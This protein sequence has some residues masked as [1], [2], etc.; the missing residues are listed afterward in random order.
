M[1][2]KVD[3]A[4]ETTLTTLSYINT[5]KRAQEKGYKVSLIYFWLRNV[6]LAIQRV[7]TRV[8]EGGHAIPEEVIKRRYIKGIKNLTQKFVP[9]C[10]Y[11]LV[12]DNSIR[13]Y[14]FVAEGERNSALK[15]HDLE[16]WE[17]IKTLE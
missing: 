2:T 11:W 17:I 5:I 16:T 3:F 4:L 6:N 14:N 15:V 8:S 13:P 7:E 9:I 10:D 1:K 12:V